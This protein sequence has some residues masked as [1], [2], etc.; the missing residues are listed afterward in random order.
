M[1]ILEYLQE[2]YTKI[3]K[4]PQEQD[5]SLEIQNLPN[6]KAHLMKMEGLL[7]NDTL[8]LHTK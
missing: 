1:T 4:N 3:I 5:I 2:C 7:P 8:L 6:K